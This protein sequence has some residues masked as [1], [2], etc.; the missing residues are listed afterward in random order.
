MT[1]S[2][3]ISLL[4]AYT[5]AAPA[6]GQTQG[7]IESTRISYTV[8]DTTLVGFLAWDPA[9]TGKRPGILIVHEWTGL[10]DYA[11]RRAMDLAREGYVAFALDMY[12]DG[13]EI[14]TSQARQVSGSVG[15]NFPLIKAR[16]EAALDLLKAQKNVDKEKIAAIGYCF[17]GGIVLN[18]ARMGTSIKGVVSFHGSMNTGLSAKEGDIRTPI[19]A[20]Q[21]EGDPAAPASTRQAFTKEM[22]SAK[23]TY[24]YIVYPGVNAHN[25]TNPAGATYHAKEAELAWGQM[26]TFFTKIF[27]S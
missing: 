23:A 8:G 1:K 2:L 10:N 5:L 4:M 11:M 27:G 21:G 26:K 14:P 25:F 6:F 7:S 22:D 9:L 3:V 24:E 16:F 17:G 20:F 13:K 15:S 12:G 19:L 18:M